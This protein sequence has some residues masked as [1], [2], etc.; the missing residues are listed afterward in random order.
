MLYVSL[1]PSEKVIQYDNLVPHEHEPVHEVR[2]DESRA[3][4]DKD[5]L[6]LWWS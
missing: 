6:L 3:T 4:R 1:V 2:P 5:A